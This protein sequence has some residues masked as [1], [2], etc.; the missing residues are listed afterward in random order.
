MSRV[1]IY[2]WSRWEARKNFITLLAFFLVVFFSMFHL[3]FEI[4]LFLFFRCCFFFSCSTSISVHFH[5]DSGLMSILGNYG[6]VLEKIVFFFRARAYS[7]RCGYS[8]RVFYFIY[9]M[10]CIRILLTFIALWWETSIY[11]IF[12]FIIFY[13]FLSIFFYFNI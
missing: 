13:C 3:F 12:F 8:I 6:M 4:F 2:T 9:V 11:F 7:I 5:F 1:R 10:L